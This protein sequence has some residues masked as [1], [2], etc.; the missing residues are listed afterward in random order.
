VLQLADEVKY[1][2]G[3]QAASQSVLARPSEPGKLLRRWNADLH[4]FHRRTEEGLN[5]VG[6]SWDPFTF[7]AGPLKVSDHDQIG[8]SPRCPAL[9]FGLQAYVRPGA[10]PAG[11]NGCG[12]DNGMK[13]PD[14]RFE[15]CCNNHDLCYGM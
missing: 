10:R 4:S 7:L 1:E 6:D 2:F 14:F 12:A 8:Y 13:F 11:F 3:Y 15:V 5:H 9:P